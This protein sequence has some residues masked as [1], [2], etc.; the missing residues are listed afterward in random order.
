MIVDEPT[1]D[2]T[3]EK[4]H[5]FRAEFETGLI[6]PV[7]SKGFGQENTDMVP[8]TLVQAVN[9]VMNL[10]QR[11]TEEMLD[12]GS[13]ANLAHLRLGTLKAVRSRAEQLEYN[14]NEIDD[15]STEWNQDCAFPNS[16]AKWALCAH[17]C[18]AVR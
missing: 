12:D 2:V 1:A 4:V 14:G 11:E 7:T 6:F 3:T 17:L 9:F 16:G 10:D 8:V 15:F 5:L 13:D 18:V